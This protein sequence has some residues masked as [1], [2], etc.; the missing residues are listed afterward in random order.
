[1]LPN[2]TP[3][4]S[5]SRSR[6]NL[7]YAEQLIQQLIANMTLE[8]ILGWVVD[9]SLKDC[10]SPLKSVIWTSLTP[11]PPL[12]VGNGLRTRNI[13]QPTNFGDSGLDNITWVCPWGVLWDRRSQN[14]NTFPFEVTFR[15]QWIT[16]PVLFCQ[17]IDARLTKISTGLARFVWYGLDWGGGTDSQSS[18]AILMP[19]PESL[20]TL[21]PRSIF[22]LYLWRRQLGK[23]SSPALSS[24]SGSDS[25]LRVTTLKDIL[26][27]AETAVVKDG[28]VTHK[29]RRHDR[30][31]ILVIIWIREVGSEIQ[32][33]F[34][35]KQM[36]KNKFVIARKRKNRDNERRQ[37]RKQRWQSFTEPC[38]PGSSAWCSWSSWHSD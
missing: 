24:G 19:R 2:I 37:I 27:V 13:T 32:T 11:T 3:A 15:G 34:W 38:S 12:A 25:A 28:R 5:I 6:W 22:T 20:R 8:N 29:R 9:L 36:Y 18:S 30:R 23:S 1:M 16:D 21:R 35:C 17:T 33:K 7:R 10:K 14:R 4:R 31:I 26:T